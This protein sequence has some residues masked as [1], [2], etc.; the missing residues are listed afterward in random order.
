VTLALLTFEVAAQDLGVADGIVNAMT[1][2][3]PFGDAIKSRSRS[4]QDPD[5]VK[6]PAS[7]PINGLLCQGFGSAFS[8]SNG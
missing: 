4:S 1:G 5:G 6:F 3:P 8:K 2:A 7:A